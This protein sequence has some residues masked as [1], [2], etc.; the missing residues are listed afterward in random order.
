[1]T[2]PKINPQQYP[3]RL[4]AMTG[5]PGSGKSTFATQMRS[6]LLVVDADHRFGEVVG[7]AAGDV[8]RL[9]DAAS[10]NVNADAIAQLLNANMPG[11]AVGTIVVDSLTAILR[12]LIVGA[13][14]DKDAGRSKNLMAGWKDKALA[15]S[16]LQDTV[17]KWGCD[18]LWIY[19]IG[20]ARDAQAREVVRPSISKT[21]LARLVRSLNLQL[22]IVVEDGR[23]G[24]KVTWARRGRPG[25]TLWD[26][27]GGW[28]GMPE[29]I[30]QAVYGGLSPED[31]DGIE[32]ATPAVF[33]SP[34]TAMAWGVEQGAFEALQHA[35]NAYEKLKREKS[36]NTAQ[37]MAALWVADVQ[38][39]L[40][41]SQG[42]PAG[43]GDDT[44]V[45]AG[46]Q[47]TP[48]EASDQSSVNDQATQL[49]LPGGDGLPDWVYRARD[50]AA[51]AADAADPEKSAVV[52]GLLKAW[53]DKYGRERTGA[54]IR[55]V[56]RV[57]PEE[58]TRPMCRWLTRQHDA[59][60]LM[61]ELGIDNG[62]QG[63]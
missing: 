39:R 10:D 22:E 21:E 1:M 63:G 20:E 37:E 31:Q 32:R 13:I 47:S 50:E 40:A 58:L 49:P 4:W 61:S 9:S 6:P 41:R 46:A 57:E 54:F 35:R 17:T 48:A 14:M 18:V 36:P 53:A 51:K 29:K 3:P 26:E 27:T 59:T 55:A 28:M 43:V 62:S 30:E 7:L 56:F 23:R 19:H 52:R 24:V 42:A 38:E 12:P 34:E 25:V 5:R 33:A 16:L 60:Q 11:M 45:E 2:F 15:M 44:S 8:Y